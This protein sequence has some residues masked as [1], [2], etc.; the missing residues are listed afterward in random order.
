M[1]VCQVTPQI[2]FNT[3]KRW[4][5][6]DPST[7]RRHPTRNPATNEGKQ[8]ETTRANTPQKTDPTNQK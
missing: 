7:A 2:L 1:G 6:N 5:R 3:L 8:N 4:N